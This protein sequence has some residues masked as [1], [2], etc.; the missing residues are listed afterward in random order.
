MAD[1]KKGYKLRRV[2]L[3]RRPLLCNGL[4]NKFPLR[5]PVLASSHFVIR[6]S[7]LFASGTYT[8]RPVRSNLPIHYTKKAPESYG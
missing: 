6:H 5:F 1:R 4:L 2:I 8:A 3:F 7:L